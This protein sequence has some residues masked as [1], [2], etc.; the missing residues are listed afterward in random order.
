MWSCGRLCA[1]RGVLWSYG[2]KLYDLSNGDDRFG[3]GLDALLAEKEADQISER[4]LR[5][6]RAPHWRDARREATLW[7]PPPDRPADRQD[8]RVGHRRGDRPDVAEVIKRVLAGES[9]W[10]VVR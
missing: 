7:L 5:G 1:E 4:V 6:K 2:G 8:H 9:L 3:T 10:S